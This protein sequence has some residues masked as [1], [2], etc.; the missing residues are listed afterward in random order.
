MH[1]ALVAFIALEFLDLLVRPLLSLAALFLNDFSQGGID[2]LGHAP[3]VTANDL[4]SAIVTTLPSGPYT[5]VI[6]ER[7]GQ[8]GVGLFEVYNLQNP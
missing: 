8:S 6:H 1:V 7:N 4:E 3:R 5:A 2:I